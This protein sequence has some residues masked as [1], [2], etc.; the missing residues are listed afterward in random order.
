[1]SLHMAD[2]EFT[3]AIYAQERHVFLQIADDD[4][5]AQYHYLKDPFA[6][7]FGLMLRCWR[8]LWAQH[9]FSPQAEV[10]YP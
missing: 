2:S 10:G 6:C 5:T 4:P 7:R 3:A 8:L 1:M 9:H